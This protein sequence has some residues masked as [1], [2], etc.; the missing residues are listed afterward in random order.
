LKKIYKY[1]LQIT[2]HQTLTLP[3]G[4]KIL[5]VAEQHDNI[6]LY[7]LVDTVTGDVENVPIIIRGTGHTAN[8]VEG[9]A[10]LGTVKLSG[11][12]LMFHVFAKTNN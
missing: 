12:R 11:G 10:F 5:S 2:D 6:V 3:K 1:I 4:S 7:A 8:Y 9:C